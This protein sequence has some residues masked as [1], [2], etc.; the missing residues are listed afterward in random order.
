MD[1]SP[2][3]LGIFSRMDLATEPLG[4]IRGTCLRPPPPLPPPPPLD[5]VAVDELLL[6]CPS[7]KRGASSIWLRLEGRGFGSASGRL[8][9]RCFGTNSNDTV[10]RHGFDTHGANDTVFAGSRSRCFGTNAIGANDD[11]VFA[12]LRSFIGRGIGSRGIVGRRFGGGGIAGSACLH[13]TG[14]GN[15]SIGTGAACFQ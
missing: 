1:L 12:G 15:G 7:P 9:C 10:F 11:T 3:P 4:I 13:I 8:G 5:V 2:G 14:R 6:L